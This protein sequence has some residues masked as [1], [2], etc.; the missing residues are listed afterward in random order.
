MISRSF[1]LDVYLGKLAR[2]LR[3]LGFDSSWRD[4]YADPELLRISLEEGR[5][6]LTRDHALHDQ[7]DPDRRHYV[8]AIEP[9]KQVLEVLQRFELVE[10]VRSGKGFL[11]RCLE[12]NTPILPVKG[13]HIH[14]RVSAEIL[15]KHQ[16]F[17]FCQRCERVYWEGSHFD[18]MR[19][20]VADLLQ[21]G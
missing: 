1:V 9:G 17:Y 16:Q 20:W 12:C 11:S 21:S 18:R 4:D 14:E 8:Q 19:K 10:T 6:L 5:V 15:L 3:M 13:H 7:A 2:H